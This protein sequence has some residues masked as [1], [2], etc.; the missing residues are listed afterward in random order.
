MKS[1]S[2]LKPA[3][4]WF[5][6][7]TLVLPVLALLGGCVT[8]IGANRA[9]VSSVYRELRQS[10]LDGATCSDA[11]RAVLRRYDCEKRFRTQPEETLRELHSKLLSDN[12]PDLLPALVELNYLRAERL[13]G[14][15][16][17]IERRA[18]T[19]FFLASSIYAF[20]CLRAAAGETEFNPFH[21]SAEMVRGLYNR[22][23]AQAFLV[24]DASS[25]VVR[26][27]AGVRRP[28]IGPV[29]VRLD[30]RAFPWPL[31]MFSEWV[32]ADAYS[33][34]GLS[35]RNR[36]AG[37]GAPLIVTARRDARDIAPP[38]LAATLFL[39]VEA[40]VEEWGAVPLR[41]SLEIYPGSTA[42]EVQIAGRNVPLEVDATAP[43][44]YTLNNPKAW[45]LGRRQF[46]S[47][48]EI[49]KS[50]IYRFQPYRPGA[51]PVVFVHGTFSSPVTWSEMVNTLASDPLLSR[52]YQFWVFVYNSGNPLIWSAA[53][54]RDALTDTVKRLDPEGRDPALRQIVLVGHSQ[55]GVLVKLAVTPTGDK[56]WRVVEVKD[57]EDLD[58]SDD[59]RAQLRRALFVEPVPYV[60]RV[61]FVAT[62]HR[63]SFKATGLAR[64]LASKLVSLPGQMVRYAG[65]LTQLGG[66]DLVPL[67]LRRRLPTS[68]DGMSPKNPL[69]LALAGMPPAPG[70]VSHSIVAV[71]GDGPVERGNDG[72]V[73]YQSAHVSYAASELVVRSRHSCLNE[74]ATIEEVR[75]ILLEH[76]AALDGQQK[77]AGAMH[78]P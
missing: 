27:E 28:L 43:L 58:I 3:A 40:G 77:P 52:R 78:G 70:V 62:P 17:P 4:R 64:K 72:L 25:A 12:R 66:K 48:R 22:A 55:G 14:S 10:A 56:L 31:N 69:L 32:M 57:P 61:I 26:P 2:P 39:R 46:F 16:N 29:D 37:L 74:P 53:E 33:V 44:A 54:L 15:N 63:G 21:P 7:P 13:R 73:A 19:D 6:R 1:L 67:G 42:G 38:C 45:K 35:V 9:T 60:S 50:G 51:I 24:P 34:R 47:S 75:R 18:A 5:V 36:H 11:T 68:I 65:Q 20:Y 41:A 71:N 8:P 30:A 76:L 59:L 23:V 49:V